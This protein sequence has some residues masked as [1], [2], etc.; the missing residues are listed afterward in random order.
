M[1]ACGAASMIQAC[2]QS[3]VIVCQSLVTR[4]HHGI[5]LDGV[6]SPRDAAHRGAQV[7]S[8]RFSWPSWAPLRRHGARGSRRL[9]RSGRLGVRVGR[10]WR[11]D[12]R[13][14]M[15]GTLGGHRGDVCT[16]VTYSRKE[17]E[18]VRNPGLQHVSTVTSSS[19]GFTT[20]AHTSTVST[21]AQHTIATPTAGGAHVCND[22]KPL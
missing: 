20:T 10:L 7:A 5:A 19:Y 9:K 6:D 3:S 22:T 16:R 4:K 18:K 15:C 14:V 17:R 12:G 1:M 21:P 2:R 8:P 13:G 11:I